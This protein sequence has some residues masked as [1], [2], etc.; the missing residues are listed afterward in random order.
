MQSEAD[1]SESDAAEVFGISGL[2]FLANIETGQQDRVLTASER[3]F[4]FPSRDV[5]RRLSSSE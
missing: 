4:E 2:S 5:G 3:G 1:S